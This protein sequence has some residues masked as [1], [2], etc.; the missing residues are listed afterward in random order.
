MNS[1]VLHAPCQS[2]QICL[3]SNDIICKPLASL[4]TVEGLPN[5]GV[6]LA[7]GWKVRAKTRAL[8]ASTTAAV[9]AATAGAA[10]ASLDLYVHDPSGT[11]S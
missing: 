5:T 9:A 8:A 3:Q 1:N 11:S 10:A 7:P 2:P 4:L 6:Q